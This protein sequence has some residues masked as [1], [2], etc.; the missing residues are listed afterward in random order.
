MTK[1][2]KCVVW[3]NPE[4]R[5]ML[6]IRAVQEDKTITEVLEEIAEESENLLKRRKKQKYEFGL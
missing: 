4:T 6:K 2:N 3:V 1:K 5:K